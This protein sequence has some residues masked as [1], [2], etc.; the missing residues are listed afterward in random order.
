MNL[1]DLAQR[2]GIEVQFV[3]MEDGSGEFV[4]SKSL[5]RLVKE[6]GWEESLAHELWHCLSF[7]GLEYKF[8]W[9]R[10]VL[11]IEGKEF[12]L[13]ERE[14]E[15][16]MDNYERLVWDEEIYA[17]RMTREVELLVE[18]GLKYEKEVKLAKIKRQKRAKR[19]GLETLVCRIALVGLLFGGLV[20]HFNPPSEMGAETVQVK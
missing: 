20:Y 4:V 11:I 6:E 3:D 5:I 17:V 18:L 15:L 1:L 7:A 2:L 10:Q 12:D 14:V 8:D 9:D 19:K 13:D 16:V